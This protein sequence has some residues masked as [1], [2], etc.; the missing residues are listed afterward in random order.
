M[1]ALAF[2]TIVL[3][4]VS[5]TYAQGSARSS[6]DEERNFV[7][8][9]SEEA[10]DFSKTLLKQD[11]SYY[12]GWL[13]L[14][15]YLH[16]RAADIT[17]Y[18]KSVEPLLRAK[19]LLEKDYSKEL[20]TR[21]TNVD[22]F[23][24]NF[25]RYQDYNYL[26]YFLR[27]AYSVLDRP[28]SSFWMA[29]E[30]Q[31]FNFQ[32][33]LAYFNGPFLA[34]AWTVYRY[35][36]HTSKEYKFLKKGL[37]ENMDFVYKLMD[38]SERRISANIKL[39]NSILPYFGNEADITS[40]YHFESIVYA[41]DKEF[42][43]AEKA[44]TEM[45]E[46]GIFPYNNYALLKMSEG[47]F[48]EAFENFDFLKK[49]EP[50]EKMLEEWLYYQGLLNTYRSHNKESILQISNWI[51]KVGSTPGYGWYNIA[52]ARSLLYQ[53]DLESAT[54]RL[55]KAKL[56]TEYHIGTTLGKEGYEQAIEFLDVMLD[57]YKLKALQ[58]ENPRWYFSLKQIGKYISHRWKLLLK[59]WKLLNKIA[60]FSDR[61]KILYDLF[62]GESTTG[63]YETLYTL[64]TYSQR[65]SID[66]YTNL[67]NQKETPEPLLPYY[68]YALSLLHAES[69][70]KK[71]AI[72]ELNISKSISKKETEF[73]SLL[74]FLILDQETELGALENNDA[75]KDMYTLYPSLLPYT[76]R[77]MRFYLTVIGEPTPLVEK[78]LN[79]MKKCRVDFVENKNG[80]DI[81][82]VTLSPL[83]QGSDEF[84]VV[85]VTQKGEKLM[86]T[87]KLS[88]QEEADG[89]K[90][91][92]ALFDIFG[93]YKNDDEK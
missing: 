58:F 70:D 69:G 84:M 2:I 44:Y 16:K 83:V 92:Y 49:I 91:A 56:F 19:H 79:R 47:L 80:D 30:Y 24:R 87:Y 23:F 15:A 17:G 62:S 10:Y 5:N 73:S 34:K 9:E 36:N 52:L 78:C 28:D 31:K 37:A 77:T 40:Y 86:E 21:A 76:E 4:S 42:A 81:P 38:S 18:Q 41:Y 63:W 53:G 33:D 89:V 72:N 3:F 54:I 43:K 57:S 12:L 35:R 32:K 27:S 90:L 60:N 8:L 93:R 68:H 6:M 67:I 61:E 7:E 66:Y 29:D 26:T 64:K 46:F 39:N 45:E 75:V 13:Y 74:S 50:Y 82:R 20:S 85:D 71:D 48:E 11:S 51:K 22:A 88:L 59:R 55:Q 65:Y 1:R 14:G 25:S